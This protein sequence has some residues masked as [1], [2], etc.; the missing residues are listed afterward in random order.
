MSDN[1]SDAG[2]TPPLNYPNDNS[3]VM[4]IMQPQLDQQAAIGFTEEDGVV[5]NTTRVVLIEPAN[6]SNSAQAKEFACGEFL[7]NPSD[8]MKLALVNK[9]CTGVHSEDFKQISWSINGVQALA[10]TLTDTGYD[11]IQVGL[12]LSLNCIGTGTGSK[13]QS[14]IDPAASDAGDEAC[15]AGGFGDGSKTAFHALLYYGYTSSY[16]FYCFDADDMDRVIEWM[17][18]SRVF[19]GFTEPHMAIEVINRRRT[20]DERKFTNPTMIT[21]V[22]ANNPGPD[23]ESIQAAFVR[24]VSRFERL[25]Y[26]AMEDPRG[27]TISAPRFGA[28][29][30]TCTY[31]PK[32]DRLGD[33][34]IELPCKSNC[35]LVLVGGIFYQAECCWMPKAL[36]VEIYGN[37]IP[38]SPMQVFNSQM[39]VVSISHLASVFH[40]QFLEFHKLK[41]NRERITDAFMPLLEGGSTFLVTRNV[42][43]VAQQMLYNT[44]VCKTIRDMLLFR[45]LSPRRWGSDVKAERKAVWQRVTE[46]V[47]CHDHN[48]ERAKWYQYLRGK[49]GNVVV[50]DPYKANSQ[51]FSPVDMGQMAADAAKDVLRDA[52]GRKAMSE[53]LEPALR[54]AIKYITKENPVQVVRVTKPPGDGILAYNFRTDIND[55]IVVFYQAID[56]PEH[57]VKCIQPHMRDTDIEA[58]RA[59]QFSLHFFGNQA[60][61][62]SLK[63]RVKYAVACAIK[64]VPYDIGDDKPIKKRARESSSSS[65]S[66]S[67]EER[68]DYKKRIKIK[69]IAGKKGSGSSSKRPP[70]SNLP[71]DKVPT[72][73]KLPSGMS[74]VGGD[75][76][77][78]VDVED[79]ATCALAWSDTHN[80]FLPDGGSPFDIPSSL[81][82]TLEKFCRSI[83]FLREKV[84]VGQC[85]FFP[86]YAPGETWAGLHKH[87]GMCLINLAYRTDAGGIIGVAIH[88]VAH[89]ASSHHDLLHGREMQ[90]LFE[91]LTSQMVPF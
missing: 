50:I 70:V 13:V 15:T 23:V 54:P 19:R 88:E 57:S 84:N 78:A 26:D 34:A 60:R 45:F 91:H 4:R 8:F 75:G 61:T 63:E 69:P 73:K 83:D 14:T 33:H 31:R 2:A 5:V 66:D 62:M 1:S 71:R 7:Q 82:S 89:E 90:G 36:V 51:L 27:R 6:F 32:F 65:D 25:M 58:S 17:C 55:S 68:E 44:D 52:K 9:K 81:P 42:H 67:D 3:E 40:T 38:K 56:D 46:A 64:E 16:L 24:A 41:S 30:H 37:G 80:V 18:I 72:M 49:S 22:C 79:S 76:R 12:P 77:P 87:G 43:T 53:L 59:M 11:I 74:G 20:D 39:R 21:R 29:K 28:W 86:A 85:Q 35:C 48:A 10:L 47:L